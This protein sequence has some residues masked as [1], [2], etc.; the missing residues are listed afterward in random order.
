MLQTLLKLIDILTVSGGNKNDGKM[1]STVRNYFA[2]R[3]G[4]RCM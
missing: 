1:C 3:I 4:D 2:T